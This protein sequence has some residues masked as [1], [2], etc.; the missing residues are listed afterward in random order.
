[1]FHEVAFAHSPVEEEMLGEEGPYNHSTTIVHVSAVIKLAHCC[2]ND[3][4]A[5]FPF[6]PGFEM[7][8]VIFPGDIG[9]FWLEWLV[10][11]GDASEKAR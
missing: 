6:C 7:L 5:C 9:I 10:H 2:V 3:W 8:M 4:V 1:M 11:A